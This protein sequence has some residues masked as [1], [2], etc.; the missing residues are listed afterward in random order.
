MLSG[1]LG[2]YIIGFAGLN[3]ALAF[4]LDSYW[5]T[6]YGIDVPLWAPFH[7]MIISGMALTGFGAIYTF[8][9]VT[10]LA[11]SINAT[12]T[13]LTAHIG[14]IVAFATTLSLFTLLTFNVLD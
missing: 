13:R 8:A 2:G 14:L 9:S 10:N 7:V 5:H 1:P 12:R 11:A 3:A 4:P 6:L